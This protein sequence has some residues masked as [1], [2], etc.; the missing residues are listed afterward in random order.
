[1]DFIGYNCLGSVEHKN[2]EVG[3]LH[4]QALSV[5]RVFKTLVLM[6]GINFY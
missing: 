3:Q 4:E 1:M 5:T 2:A 6:S